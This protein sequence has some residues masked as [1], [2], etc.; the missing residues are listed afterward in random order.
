MFTILT[1]AAGTTD[2][3]VPAMAQDAF[4]IAAFESGDGAITSA[5][6]PELANF[7]RAALQWQGNPP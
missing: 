4:F 3:L 2:I 1:D 7:D 5:E 6:V